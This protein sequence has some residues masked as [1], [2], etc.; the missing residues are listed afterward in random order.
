VPI[1]ATQA[2]KQVKYIL[3]DAG[4]EVLFISTQAQYD[5][6]REVLTSQTRL[7]AIISFER[8]DTGAIGGRIMHFDEFL[9]WGRAAHEAEPELYETLRQSASPDS[10]ATLIYTS[11]TTGEPKGVMLTHGNI[12]S[13]V[14]LNYDSSELQGERC[15]AQLFALLAHLRAQHN[16]HVFARA[17]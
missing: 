9:N 11:G 3:Q 2:P 14:L 1:Y 12:T 17:L 7:R 10:L 6:L 16:L 15:R 4:A 5:R 8:I 13:N